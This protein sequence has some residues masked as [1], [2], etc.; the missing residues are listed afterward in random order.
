M[1]VFHAVTH[2]DSTRF[3]AVSLV[4]ILAFW[5]AY[6]TFQV[7]A[8]EEL[9]AESPHHMPFTELIHVFRIFFV[10]DF[11]LGELEG[12]DPSI[13]EAIYNGSHIRGNINN[14]NWNKHIHWGI[15]LFFVGTTIVS[16][17]VM[18]VYIGLLGN[19][20]TDGKVHRH[21]IHQR[22]KARVTVRLLLQRY[23]FV[24]GF[25]CGSPAVSDTD[26]EAGSSVS[27]VSP[28]VPATECEYKGC[29]I[30][31]DPHSLMDFDDGIE[32]LKKQNEQLLEDNREMRQILQQLLLRN[33]NISN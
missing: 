10:A 15:Q 11:D 18:N 24:Q 9:R 6:C 1:P 17:V 4:L 33:A 29:W 19:L 26:I 21:A 8:N 23:I 5:N 28:D 12:E 30:F 27:P 32:M 14:P 16:L 22:F 31:F 3:L 25:K 7:D 20:Y 2:H 13:T